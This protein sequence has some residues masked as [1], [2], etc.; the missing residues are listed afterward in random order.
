MIF[1][2]DGSHARKDN[3]PLNMNVLRKT[4]LSRIKAERISLQKALHGR[5]QPGCSPYGN[6]WNLNAVALSEA[7]LCIDNPAASML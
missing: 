5:T 3:S 1:G 6:S 7:D 2:E 4:A